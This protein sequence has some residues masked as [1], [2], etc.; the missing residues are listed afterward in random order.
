MEIDF[1][2]SDCNKCMHWLCLSIT[3]STM[4]HTNIPVNH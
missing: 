4:C 1:L 3:L 2:V